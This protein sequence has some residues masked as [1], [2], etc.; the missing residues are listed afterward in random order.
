MASGIGLEVATCGGYTFA[1]GIHESVGLSLMMAGVAT[2]TYHAQDLSSS[3]RTKFP[4]PAISQEEYGNYYFP[5]QIEKKNKETSN[6]QDKPEYKKP[7][8]KFLEKKE[9]K[10]CLVGQRE[11]SLTRASWARSLQKDSWM[12]NMAQTIMKREQI[13]LLIK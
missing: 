1:L 11:I 13:V 5:I 6:T 2:T 10:M 8:P 3:R 9:L 7:K 4:S 12:R